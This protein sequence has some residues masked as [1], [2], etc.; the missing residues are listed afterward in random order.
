MIYSE[1]TFDRIPVEKWVPGIFL[2]RRLLLLLLLIIII[3][4]LPFFPSS[5]LS[6]SPSWLPAS[7]GFFFW[8]HAIRMVFKQQKNFVF[9]FLPSRFLH[10][11]FPSPWPDLLLR[12]EGKA[13]TKAL[14]QSSLSVPSLPAQTDKLDKLDRD[15]RFCKLSLRF[16]EW[17]A[18]NSV[19]D[20]YMVNLTS[21][22]FRQ[23]QIP[24]IGQHRA[25]FDGRTKQDL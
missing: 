8:S 17:T 16:Q 5:F 9:F 24:G 7:L 15:V 25:V 21:A 2:L 3:I 22:N 4:I 19:S 20:V 12:I 1:T 18:S 13:S 23:T 6:S 11:L 14:D 10:K